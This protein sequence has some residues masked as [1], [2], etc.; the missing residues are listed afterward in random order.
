MPIQNI[1]IGMI[2]FVI[3]LVVIYGLYKLVRPKTIIQ[4]TKDLDFDKEETKSKVGRDLK[5]QN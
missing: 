3:L 4:E 2:I 5:D 1:M